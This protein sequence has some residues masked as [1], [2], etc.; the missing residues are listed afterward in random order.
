M[1]ALKFFVKSAQAI[2][3][4]TSSMGRKADQDN[5][6][7]SHMEEEDR[8]RYI[9]KKHFRMTQAQFGAAAGVSE[10]AV[11]YWEK[12]STRPSWE[13]LDRIQTRLRVSP[14]W[15]RDGIGDMLVI[16]GNSPDALEKMLTKEQMALLDL[17]DAMTNEQQVVLLADAK[18]TVR[19]NAEIIRQLG[20]KDLNYP[21]NYKPGSLPAR[22]APNGPE[23]SDSETNSH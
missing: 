14:R 22:P 11:S 15:I 21:P 13:A 20:G 6:K 8:I 12:G 10:S 7:S 19:N 16:P 3:S 17:F 9:R 5:V 1:S 23:S 4:H 2:R 18:R